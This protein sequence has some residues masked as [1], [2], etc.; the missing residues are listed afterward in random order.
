MT[1]PRDG[2][3]FLRT[4]TGLLAQ[5]GGDPVR[6]QLEARGITNPRLL[7]AFRRLP[8]W[9]FVP[10]GALNAWVDHPLPIG[11]GQTISQPYVVAYMLQA[12][13]PRPGDRVLEIG[14]GSG[15]QT[16][17]LARLCRDVYTIEMHDD[18]QKRARR[19]LGHLGITN[20][21]YAIGDG[22]FGWDAAAPFDLI[23]GSAAATRIP[24]TLARQLAPCGRLVLPVGPE[25][26][27]QELLLMRRSPEGVT[28]VEKLIEVRFVPMVGG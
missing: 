8:R 24:P 18:L 13:D 15:Y 4:L 20:V 27:T 21:Q 12:A 28:T 22:H 1:P 5:L 14:T 10:G 17:L 3:G 19:V 16:A 9:R 2:S 7:E 23:V 25:G 11:A 26:E 6:R